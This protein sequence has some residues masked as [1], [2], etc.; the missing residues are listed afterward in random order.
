MRPS[1]LL[2]AMVQLNAQVAIAAFSRT[3]HRPRA[4][5]RLSTTHSQPALAQA[6]PGSDEQLILLRGLI[7][8]STSDQEF[9]ELCRDIARGGSRT[10]PAMLLT[11]Q[12]PY[13]Q[14]LGWSALGIT[15]AITGDCSWT[16]RLSTASSISSNGYA[17]A[18][19]ALP[20]AER[21]AAA[22]EQT[23]VAVGRRSGFDH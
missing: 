21:K 16:V 8:V 12:F 10:L 13:D 11:Q 5:L 3:R 9:E 23:R 22:Y 2:G 14:N 15:E 20:S 18:I 17:Y 19:A 7:S 6:K 1:F 4:P